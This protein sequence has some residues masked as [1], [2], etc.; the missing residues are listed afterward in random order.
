M[1]PKINIG[2]L[3]RKK[4]YEHGQKEQWLAKK[5]GCDESKISRI[6]NGKSQSIN[7]NTLISI[8]ICLKYNFFN[9]FVQYINTQIDN[10]NNALLYTFI[11]NERHI[12]EIIRKIKDEK[13]IKSKWLAEQIHLSKGDVSN[14]YQRKDIDVDLLAIICI[15]LNFNFFE[16]YAKYINEQINEI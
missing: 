9:D 8:C 6:C 15:C 11:D 3:I 4:L 7:T 2:E 5:I 10:K 16:I 13:G 12:G 14:I 1:T